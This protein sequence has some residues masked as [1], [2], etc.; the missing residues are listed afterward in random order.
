MEALENSKYIL[1][2]HR[3][4]T[5]L[6]A[7]YEARCKLIIRAA[8]GPDALFFP[9]TAL[10]AAGATPSDRV[11][12]DATYAETISEIYQDQTSPFRPNVSSYDPTF[13]SAKGGLTHPDEDSDFGP[14]PGKGHETGRTVDFG[15]ASSFTGEDERFAYKRARSRLWEMCG[16]RWHARMEDGWWRPLPVETRRWERPIAA[17]K[18]DG[19]VQSIAKAREFESVFPGDVKLGPSIDLEKKAGLQPENDRSK[20]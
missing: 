20:F 9:E 15:M 10:P 13:E 4:I 1:T 12:S 11:D 7:L 18:R 6:D 19:L 17:S 5:L 2:Q 16:A 8:A 3:M 14:I